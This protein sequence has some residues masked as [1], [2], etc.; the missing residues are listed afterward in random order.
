M[1]LDTSYD[2]QFT[3]LTDLNWLPWIGDNFQ[4][5]KALLVGESHYD[6]NDGWLIYKNATRNFINNQ[7]LNSHNPDF[8]N[9]LFFIKLDDDWQGADFLAQHIDG[10]T[11]IKVQL[12]GRLTFDKK[13]SGKNIFIA[14]PYRNTWYLFDH[15][16]LLKVFLDTFLNKMAISVSWAKKGGYSWKH[17]SKQ[18]LQLIEP[19]KL[20]PLGNSV[21]Q[22]EAQSISAN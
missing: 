18:I 6:D 15:D 4:N 5:K 8:K 21:Y 13:Y 7:G 9:R 17:L 11:F 14:F 19:Y 16:E 22:E 3:T 12:K 2:N 20:S 1:L 10:V